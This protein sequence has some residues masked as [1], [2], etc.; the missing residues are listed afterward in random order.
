MMLLLETVSIKKKNIF[1]FYNLYSQVVKFVSTKKNIEQDKEYSSMMDHLINCDHCM[2]ELWESFSI[3]DNILSL[4]VPVHQEKNI[5]TLELIKTK[6]SFSF[7]PIQGLWSVIDMQIPVS[8]LSQEQQLSIDRPLY[9][10]VSHSLL[11]INANRK[12]PFFIETEVTSSG[13]S[14]KISTKN[15][16][17]ID[18]VYY[19]KDNIIVEKQYFSKSKKDLIFFIS[20]NIEVEFFYVKNKKT[21]P[22]CFIKIKI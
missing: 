13:I 7:I 1:S 6:N 18:E 3:R 20:E 21:C 2:K 15:I 8:T 11:P 19:M 22:L 16:N 4:D 9:T 5:P 10:R 17:D 14:I 12:N